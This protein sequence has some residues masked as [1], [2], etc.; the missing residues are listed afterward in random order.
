MKIT[1]LGAARTVTGSMHL[2]EAGGNSILLDCGL[3]QGRRQEA[4]DKNIKLA[5]IAVRADAVV[6]SHAHIDHSGKLPLLVHRG[7]LGKI[8]A[9]RGTRQLSDAMLNDSAQIQMKDFEYLEEH[10]LPALDPLYSVDDVKETMTHFVE[11]RYGTWFDICPGFRARFLDAGHI[12]GSAVTELE[13]TEKGNV[14]RLCF[15]GDLGRR[16]M[17]ILRDPEALPDCDTVITE[18]TYGD[19]LHGG[20][21]VTENELAALVVEQVQRRGPIIIPAFSVGRTQN[22]IYALYKIYKRGAAPRLPIFVDSPLSTRVTKI[23]S[24]NPECFDEEALAVLGEKGAPFYFPEVRYIESVEESKALN[25]HKGAF[26]VISA[27]GMCENGRILH[28]LKNWIEKPEALVLIVGFQAQYTL[29]R[30]ILSGASRVKIFGVERDVLARVKKMNAMSAHADRNDL[31]HYVAP[32][33]RHCGDVFVVHGEPAPAES[34][35]QAIRDSG[36]VRVR[37]PGEGESF[38]L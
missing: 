25:D 14:R 5:E 20:V 8:H 11:S 30:R 34:L 38:E 21:E 1:F 27:S 37:V 10:D 13:I 29:G 33:A 28:H 31:I 3:Y 19:R 24:Q 9:T 7:F 26:I 16:G 35:A 36:C 17:P 15:T 2:I 22:L 12:L 18:S 6:L 4:H 32:V 23:V